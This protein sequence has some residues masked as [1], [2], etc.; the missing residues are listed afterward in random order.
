MVTIK[1][2]LVPESNVKTRTFGHYNKRKF[3]T[4]HETGNQS[5][6][7][8]AQSH[9]NLQSNTNPRKASWHWQ[10]DDKLA[11]QSYEHSVSCWAGGDGRGDGNMNS[12]HIEICVNSDSDFAK[13]FENAAALVR[14]IMKEE[15]LSVDRV[16]QHNH[17]SGKNC[18]TFLRNGSKG[19]N[20]N[21]FI[22]KVKGGVVQVSSPVKDYYQI[23]DNSPGVKALQEKL[24]K[25]GFNL[26][27]DS[28]FGKD[29]E[30]AVTSFQRT[31]GLA[32][33]GIAGNATQAKLDTIIA[34][35][36]KTKLVVKTSKESMP[37]AW[38]KADVEEAMKLGI[39]DGSRLHDT[40]TRQEAIVLTMR[41]AGLSPR[42]K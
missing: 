31:S 17:W 19:I 23:G 30:S 21:G 15:N 38:A 18:P 4:I 12:I 40:V 9:A 28:I 33:D 11:I 1:Q 22:Q 3:I 36:E 6:G 13:T 7:A 10:V 34:I 14:Y 32:V 37:S 42:I 5:K 35:T 26:S 24:N 27:V 41:A 20:W 16:V 39:T 25:V 8:G 2:Q 29:T